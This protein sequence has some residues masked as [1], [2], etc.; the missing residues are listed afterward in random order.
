MDVEEKM[1]F[2]WMKKRC[3]II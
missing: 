3:E 1:K 2:L